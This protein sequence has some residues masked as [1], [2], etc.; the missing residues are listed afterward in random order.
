MPAGK[1]SI[2]I[3]TLNRKKDLLRTLK[4]LERQCC[5]VPWELLV[6]DNGS[7]DGAFDAAGRFARETPLCV[8]VIQEPCRGVSHARNRALR[9]AGG[10][11]LV[12]LD[13]DVDSDPGLLAAHLQAFE[14][15]A[16]L[17]SGG[18]ILPLLPEN[19]PHWLRVS[20]E[21]EIGGPTTRYEYGVQVWCIHLGGVVAAPFSCNMGLRR[22]VALELGGFRTDLG[23]SADGRRIGGED[24]ELMKRFQSLGGKI[25]YLPDALVIHRVQTER[26]TE[27][28]Y[29]VWNIAYGRA[30]V[31]MR[32][33]P[34]VLGLPLK[35]IEQLFRILRYS[36]L[37]R[38]LL[39]DSKAKRLRKRCQALGR[40]LELLKVRWSPKQQGR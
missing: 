1:A 38:S 7:E 21:E 26:A 39:R 30:S 15:P 17:A 2:A 3:C 12:F 28:Y 11:V 6:V 4:E 16:V 31:R 13:D 36:I 29:R 22:S 9:E 18:R 14:D 32:G 8:R 40:I 33:R 10:E 24:T 34:G 19:T 25:L 35:I 5:G 37:P 20:Q 23:F 27:S